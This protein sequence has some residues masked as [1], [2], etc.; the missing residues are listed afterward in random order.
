[1]G[2]AFIPLWRDRFLASDRVDELAGPA[3]A[4]L[5]LLF[6]HADPATG[7]LEDGRGA[8]WSL[9]R[10][11]RRLRFTGAA[12]K[13]F[14][15]PWQSLLEAECVLQ[16]PDGAFVV[17]GFAARCSE[18]LRGRGE[19][20]QAAS[21]VHGSARPVQAADRSTKRYAPSAIDIAGESAYPDAEGQTLLFLP[22]GLSTTGPPGPTSDEPWASSRTKNGSRV[23]ASASPYASARTNTNPSERR[24]PPPQPPRGSR[25]GGSHEPLGLGPNAG[26]RRVPRITTAQLKSDELLGQLAADLQAAGLAPPGERGEQLVFVQ[27]EHARLVGRDPPAIFA[28][29]VRDGRWER[30]SDEADRR[31]Q[32]RWKR[33]RQG[34]EAVA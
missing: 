24:E 27:A 16:D 34:E 28:K 6:V 18:A 2:F 32:R 4:L 17:F 19:T 29:N 21:S 23:G 22:G 11:R 20:P 1:M 5:T 15:A 33:W 30:G 10:I 12:A 14:P 25:S 31:G 7:R 8:P 3:R 9:A 13:A 26:R